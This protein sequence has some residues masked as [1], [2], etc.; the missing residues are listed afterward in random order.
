MEVALPSATSFDLS[1]LLVCTALSFA[2]HT[3]TLLP[4]SHLASTCPFV[5][6]SQ[7][8]P[9]V[10]RRVRPP[11]RQRA[12]LS[13][14]PRPSHAGSLCGIDRSLSIL[15]R[16]RERTSP[17]RGHR[18][19]RFV[20][21][22]CTP[23]RPLLPVRS[24]S[25]PKIS[26]PHRDLP[27]TTSNPPHPQRT[28]FLPLRIL[29]GTWTVLRIVVCCLS[30]QRIQGVSSLYPLRRVRPI[31]RSIG[32]GLDVAGVGLPRGRGVP[33]ARGASAATAAHVHVSTSRIV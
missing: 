1:L 33:F 19:L 7:E 25:L 5:A 8:L 23:T 16:R 24:R 9:H 11:F 29:A 27:Q 3:R 6:F 20:D 22:P 15:P 26:I 32:G 14:R 2:F 28:H 21:A 31:L 13:A 10:S 4:M 17:W 30:P 18:H 12:D